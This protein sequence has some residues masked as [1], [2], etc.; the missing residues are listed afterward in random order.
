MA[1]LT[2]GWNDCVYK[3]FTLCESLARNHTL[4]VRSA[5]FLCNLDIWVLNSYQLFPSRQ[6]YTKCAACKRLKTDPVY[7]PHTNQSQ[8]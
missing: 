8:R 3:S 4:L 1:T 2:H 5:L 6:A 7:L